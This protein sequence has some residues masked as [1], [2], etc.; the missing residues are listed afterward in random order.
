MTEILHITN[1]VWY[2]NFSYISIAVSDSCSGIMDAIKQILSGVGVKFFPAL[3]PVSDY[4]I[5]YDENRTDINVVNI[6]T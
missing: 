4:T 6:R 1:Q 2:L 5:G 3:H